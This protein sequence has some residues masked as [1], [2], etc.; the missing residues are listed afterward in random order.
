MNITFKQQFTF[1]KNAVK[2]FALHLGWQEKLT[3]Q[4]EVVDDDTTT[5][6][7][8]HLENEEYDNP[9]TFSEFVDEKA[10]EHT[11][12]F[13]KSWAQTLKDSYLS[14]QVNEFK[15]TIE[16]SLN[17]QIIQ[18]VEDALVSEIIEE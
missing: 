4:I 15:A 9:Q 3:R 8:I 18:P 2:G 1:E 12:L 10:R 7:T 6:P 11:L 13:T 5:P 16:P 14:Q 17:A